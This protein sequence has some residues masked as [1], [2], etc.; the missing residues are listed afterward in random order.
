VIPCL[1]LA[2]GGVSKLDTVLYGYE[3]S[4]GQSLERRRRFGVVDE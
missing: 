2:H 1:P 3:G 4:Y